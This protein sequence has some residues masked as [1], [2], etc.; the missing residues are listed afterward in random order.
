MNRKQLLLVFSMMMV[1]GNAA[2][3]QNKE[4]TAAEHAALSSVYYFFGTDRYNIF[5]H[6]EE[7]SSSSCDLI[8][9]SLRKAKEHNDKR[10]RIADLE[11]Q[12]ASL[13]TRMQQP[14]KTRLDKAKQE[15]PY[16][17]ETYWSILSIE[18]QNALLEAG[19]EVADKTGYS[20]A[21]SMDQLQKALDQ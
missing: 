17:K 8:I 21:A 20:L 12:L 1:G 9:D 10:Y 2:A 19:A 18:E 13:T 15:H 7:N 5:R 11:Q 4:R 16:G 14:V 3:D 6:C